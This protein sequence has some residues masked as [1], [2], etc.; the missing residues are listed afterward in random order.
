MV[1]KRLQGEQLVSV[2]EVPKQEVDR[3][4][5]IQFDGDGVERGTSRVV[6]L[7][8]LGVHLGDGDEGVNHLHV[9]L[10]RGGM[11][12]A[13]L[14]MV[15]SKP[16]SLILHGKLVEGHVG[17]RSERDGIVGRK[18]QAAVGVCGV[19]GAGWRATADVFTKKGLEQGFRGG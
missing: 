19:Y 5:A 11:L 10:R 8:R 15:S 12:S 3:A 2:A 14:E 17:I 16:D 9:Y 1:I 4:Q 6:D 13:G 7:E 18:P